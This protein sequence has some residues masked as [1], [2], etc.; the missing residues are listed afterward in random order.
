MRG[1]DVFD[2]HAEGL[3]Y[4]DLTR[5][6]PP[7][8]VPRDHLAQFR[9]DV[10]SADQSLAHGEHHVACFS[11]RTHT[12]VDKEP[13]TGDEFASHFSLVWTARTDG[14]DVRTISHPFALDHRCPCR[15]CE[16]DDIGVANRFLS[17]RCSG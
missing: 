6:A 17:R 4:R 15:C 12:R 7:L 10:L 8:G 1:C 11:E 3:E 14:A 9:A 5:I 2:S 16:D 13:R